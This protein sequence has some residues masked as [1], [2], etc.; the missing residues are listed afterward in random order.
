MITNPTNLIQEEDKP[1]DSNPS[2]L[3][4]QI[5]SQDYN[6]PF[7]FH[8]G[9]L[10][11]LVILNI[12]WDFRQSVEHLLQ[13]LC[14]LSYVYS[15]HGSHPNTVA[16]VERKF[17]VL[18]PFQAEAICI[19]WPDPESLQMLCLL[20]LIPEASAKV[21]EVED[22]GDVCVCMWGGGCSAGVFTGGASV[23]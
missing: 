10:G 5:H 23:L 4:V 8:F 7:S 3:K 9:F 14:P 11:G 22:T 19:C 15:C 16:G 17:S 12:Q 20:R 6:V 21:A 2:M 18:I 13:N 1:P